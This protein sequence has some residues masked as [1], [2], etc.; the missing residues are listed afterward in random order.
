MPILVYENLPAYRD[1]QRREARNR[2]REFTGALHDI[3][4]IKI[5]AMSLRDNL[6]LDEIQS[7]FMFN[8]VP[9][10]KELVF[11]LWLLSP[12]FDKWSEETGWRKQWLFGCRW[13]WFSVE[14][15]QSFFH[16]RKCRRI[17]K[18]AEVE[19]GKT[20]DEKSPMVQATKA[21]FDYVKRM[22]RDCPNPAGGNGSHESYFSYLANWADIVRAEYKCS[23]HEVLTT[24]L[25]KLWQI[26]RAI[27][28]RKDPAATWSSEECQ[29]IRNATRKAINEKRFTIEDFQKGIP[30]WDGTDWAKN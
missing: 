8:R 13:Q 18:L 15:W 9:N 25:P 21:C 6:L 2:E 28:K 3:C 14:F 5:R 11:F 12:E 1:A 26:I 29:R 4:G 17:L 16:G 10:T 7:P 30:Q 22:M 23:E 27:T 19:R 20:L 24:S